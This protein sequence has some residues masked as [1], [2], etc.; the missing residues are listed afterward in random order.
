MQLASKPVTVETLVLA[1]P[2]LIDDVL[3][4]ADN[5]HRYTAC[6]GPGK[7]NLSD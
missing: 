3:Q 1:R 5:K 6:A 4:Q 2:M 7:S